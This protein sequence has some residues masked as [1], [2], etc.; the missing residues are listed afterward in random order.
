[1]KRRAADTPPR[2]VLV[3]RPVRNG[4]LAHFQVG[5]HTPANTV[6]QICALGGKIG[7]YSI[8]VRRLITLEAEFATGGMVKIAAA[9]WYRAISLLREEKLA[10]VGSIHSHPGALAVF[11]SWEDTAT[12]RQMFP[13]GVSM[14]IN[15]HR[16][17]I[18]AFHC[19][20]ERMLLKW[21]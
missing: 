4:I 3:D 9:E 1:M 7:L 18:A 16:K 17:K 20:G 14:V 12:H 10:L 19:K 6:E 13:R 11:L 2:Y 5:L 8:H 21:E 15:P